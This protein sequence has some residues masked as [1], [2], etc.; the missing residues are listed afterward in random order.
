[1]RIR[2][3][4]NRMDAWRNRI[5]PRL[6]CAV[7]NG[8]NGVRGKKHR[9]SPGAEEHIF[10]ADDGT[11]RIYYC[12]RR[13]GNLFKRD[14]MRRVVDLAREYHL[15]TI[16]IVPGGLFVD[17]GAN[18]GELGLW[19]RTRNLAYVAF[20]P[21]ALEARCCD[22][23]N[24]DGRPETRREALWKE[25]TT[26]T[27]YSNPESADSSVF[28]GGGSSSRIEVPAVVLDGVVDLA[29]VSG[30]VVIK[31]EAEGAEPEVLEGATKTLSAVDWVTVDCGYE[32][33]KQ[34]AHT[35]VET[36]VLLQDLGFR[37]QRANMKRV[38]ALYR[39][40]KR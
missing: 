17:C 14:V 22:L 27:L 21:E 5:P 8:V 10:L 28:E 20:E 19:A 40:T 31:I 7:T 34:K 32:R 12:R 39:N 36:N 29:G 16:D 23:N 1:M 37:L 33:G 25:A 4:R 38:T 18:I 3:L 35:F 26:L 13:R 11:T 2:F 30:T 9:I 15:D 6:Y 24:F